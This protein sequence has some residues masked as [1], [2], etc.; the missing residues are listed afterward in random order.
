MITLV[1]DILAVVLVVSALFAIEEKRPIISVV[2]LAAFFLA[3]P[4]LYLSLGAVF[5]AV[6]QF[7][8]GISTAAALFLVGQMFEQKAPRPSSLRKNI[9]TLGVFLAVALP[10][11]IGLGQIEAAVSSSNLPFSVALWDL[12]ALD[13]LAQ[14]MVLL[15]TAIGVAVV[16]SERRRG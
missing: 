13:V 12:R 7:A 15:V 6:F 11:V 2:C 1:N 14:A 10:S 4:L 5:A 3:L 8:I 16:L 9:S